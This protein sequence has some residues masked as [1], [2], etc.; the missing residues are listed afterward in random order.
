MRKT[1]KDVLKRGESVDALMKRMDKK[2]LSEK[3]QRVIVMRYGL[4]GSAGMTCQEIADVWATDITRQ[5][6]SRLEQKALR[7][8]GRK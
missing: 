3:Q 2:E 1:P 6:I 4:S 8:L 7:N 5:G